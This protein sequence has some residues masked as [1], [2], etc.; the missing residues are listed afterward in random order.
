MIYSETKGWV[1]L[2][3]VPG[4]YDLMALQNDVS[5]YLTSQT[6]IDAGE[7]KY[8]YVFFGG[9]NSIMI[10]EQKHCMRLKVNALTVNLDAM[11][12]SGMLSEILIG[13]D[14]CDAISVDTS[15]NNDGCYI[16]DP[17]IIVKGYS[18]ISL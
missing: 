7:F 9:E 4:I 3:L 2:K 14:F 1:D 6:N 5:I 18:E 13:F 11:I 15:Y 17:R 10:N 8:L 12:K 16:L